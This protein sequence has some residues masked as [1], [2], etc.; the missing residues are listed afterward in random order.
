MTLEEK[1]SEMKNLSN[2]VF[3][4]LS[5]ICRLISCALILCHVMGLVK[6]DGQLP[7]FTLR[8]VYYLSVVFFYVACSL[9][10]H[11]WC[12]IIH[13][14]NFF[15][16]KISRRVYKSRFYINK[17]V[18]S[19]VATLVGAV[20]V[21]MIFVDAF[22]PGKPT[23]LA[24]TMTLTVVCSAML[25]TFTVVGSILIHRLGLFFRENYDK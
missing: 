17:V 12:M 16:G 11:E 3:L 2:F 22:D 1:S 4:E 25:V 24:L 7:V 10:I 6:N 20:N 9:N 13:R 8:I 21:A 15:G 23:Q 5:L 14:V 19:I 18:F